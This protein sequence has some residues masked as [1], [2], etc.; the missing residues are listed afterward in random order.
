MD[1]VSGF[2]REEYGT[3]PETVGSSPGGAGIFG[4]YTE[5]QEGFM[6]TVA[7]DRVAEVA[8]SPRSDAALRFHA[9]HLGE[10]KRA[11]INTLRYK[12]EHRWANLPKGVIA[13]FMARTPNM[14]GLNITLHVGIPGVP[15]LGMRAALLAACAKA[16]AKQCG[17]KL[18]SDELLELGRFVDTE[19]STE[20][21]PV[22][23]L[24]TTLHAKENALLYIDTRF[25][26][27]SHVPLDLGDAVFVVTNTGVSTESVASEIEQRARDCRHG[28]ALLSGEG[29]EKTL[30]DYAP[31]DFR[32][33]DRALPERARRRCLHVVE[34]NQRVQEALRL[35]RRRDAFG[36]GK[37][38]LHSH[39][40]QRDL[41]EISCPEVDWLV[42]RCSETP[43]IYGAAMSG[44]GFG[45]CTTTLLELGAMEAYYRRLKEYERIFG[46]HAETFH[47]QGGAALQ[48]E[49]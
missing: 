39:E 26:R 19:Y 18:S 14:T 44:P 25:T 36:L 21:T 28:V 11:N 31:A 4:S 7:I 8:V 10:R 48:M 9:A 30:R 15:G 17:R 37:T 33:P 42:K 47:V 29:Q 27:F 1:N 22:S 40:S 2:H 3:S 13:W 38:L 5:P 23:E 41:Y 35:L 32:T 49:V 12:R 46:F 43:G 34:E 6:L 16:V 24:L 20:E 45:G